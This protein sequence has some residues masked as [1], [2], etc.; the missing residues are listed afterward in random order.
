MTSTSF[1]LWKRWRK[2]F[3]C[4]AGIGVVMLGF[5]E[6][7]FFNGWVLIERTDRAFGDWIINVSGGPTER[8]DLVLLGIDEASLRLDAP[9]PT[10]IASIPALTLMKGRFPWNRRVWAYTIDRLVDA[11]AKLIVLDLV[12]SEPSDPEADKVLADALQRHSDKVILGS[13]LSPVAVFNSLETENKAL[14]YGLTE[15]TEEFIFGAK[16][17]RSGYVNFYKDPVD[18]L[19]RIARYTT[20]LGIE[21][22]QMRLM[23]EPEFRSLA[24]EVIHAMGAE[25]PTG[26]QELRF[27][28]HLN[29]Q[30]SEFY[31]PKSIYGIFIEKEWRDN[32]DNGRFFRDKVVLIGPVAERFQD[33]HN[34]PMGPLTGPQLHLQ[35]IACGLNKAF[36]QRITD[37][38]PGMILLGLVALA[39]TRWVSRPLVSVFGLMAII[40]CVA[41]LAVWAGA[42]YSVLLPV[43]GGLLALGSGW[44]VAQSYEMVTER[45]EKGRLRR[46]FRRFVSRDVAD[47]MITQQDEWKETAAGVKRR[48]VVLFSDV[49]GFTERSEHTDPGYLVK[50]LNEYLTTMVAVIF[51]HGGTLD[52]FIGDA[53][54]AHWGALGGGNDEDHAR[55]AI[56]AARD[57]ITELARMNA[58][59]QAAGK[60]P[61]QIG[62]GLHLGEAIAGEI[63]SPDRTEFGVIGDTV[64]LA[65]RLE[66]LTKT[67]HCEVIY[68]DEVRIASGIDDGA[69]DLGQVKVKGRR[70]PVRLFGIGNEEDARE[71]L[72]SFE[73]DA[74]G[75]ILMSVK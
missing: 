40:A 50:Q 21:N 14:V 5:G 61:F 71:Q 4:L 54:M 9:D 32:Y 16:E 42:A 53:V 66:G 38:W 37:P 73:R 25:V 7:P 55:K 13:V 33:M 10:E 49:R 69:M 20:T 44:S 19:I 17:I 74:N 51:R 35:A 70:N 22:K 39:W 43:S 23:G 31:A 48:V 28:R 1:N 64:N 3:A 75:V 27:P 15:P 65:S 46:D 30:A 36:I 62:V 41:G 11:G 34:T 60:A 72:K 63:G 29:Y 12:F 68:S 6:L 45:L 8:Q 26:N 59:W 18:E 47:A 2:S 67:F 57:M 56:L 52:K 24:A 58:T